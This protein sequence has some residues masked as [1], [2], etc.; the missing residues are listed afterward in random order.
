M[1]VALCMRLSKQASDVLPLSY[2]SLVMC[3]NS[4]ELRARANWDGANG[5]S[6]RKLLHEIEGEQK[7]GHKVT[8]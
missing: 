5:Q 1:N 7:P 2:C 8:R 3:A 4:E 6:R